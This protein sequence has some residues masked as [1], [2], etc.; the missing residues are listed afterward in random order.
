VT[1][2]SL[3][4]YLLALSVAATNALAF[5]VLASSAGSPELFSFWNRPVW[6]CV[7]L[8]ALYVLCSARLLVWYHDRLQRYAQARRRGVVRILPVAFGVAVCGSTLSWWL[9]VVVAVPAFELYAVLFR[10]AAA[11]WTLLLL[12]FSY[13]VQLLFLSQSTLIWFLAAG[14]TWPLVSIVRPAGRVLSL[15]YAPPAEQRPSAPL[16]FLKV[17]NVFGYL[18]FFLSLLFQSG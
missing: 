1:A 17:W 18:V 8:T 13:F 3:R 7:I 2:G 12:P 10:G 16:W 4:A 6:E 14:I 11:E 9:T 15:Y 5:W